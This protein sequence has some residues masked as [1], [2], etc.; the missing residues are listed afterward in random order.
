MK[1]QDIIIED[2]SK[3]QVDI[4]QGTEGKFRRILRQISIMEGVKN[5][6]KPERRSWQSKDL[7]IL[8]VFRLGSLA[9]LIWFFLGVVDNKAPFQNVSLF[10]L[11]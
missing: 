2:D 6:L 9:C 7:D 4:I 1:I 3:I 10:S 8:Y 5:L 11:N